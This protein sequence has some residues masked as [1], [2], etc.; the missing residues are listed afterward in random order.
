[1]QLSTSKEMY[2][3][4]CLKIEHSLMPRYGSAGNSWYF[5]VAITWTGWHSREEMR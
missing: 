3:T 2:Y 1:M 4:A 5:T